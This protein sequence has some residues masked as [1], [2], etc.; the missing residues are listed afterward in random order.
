MKRLALLRHAKSGWDDPVARDFDRPLNAKGKRAAQTM[1][2]YMRDH[3][4]HYDRVTASPAI[5]VVETLDQMAIG[6]GETLAPSWDRRAYLASATT[7]LDLVQEAPD[8][9]NSLLLVG[10][11][12][13]LED[14]ALLLVPDRAGDAVRDRVEQKYPTA[15]L[16]EI[17]FDADRWSDIRAGAGRM[18]R[19]IR[20]RDLDPALGPDA[21]G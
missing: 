5:R 19:F 6:L 13:G 18:L 11:N 17:G 16:V 20:P 10:H 8:V 4:L 9:A 14:L 3:G 1:G 7:L 15:S 2:R 12:P 21:K